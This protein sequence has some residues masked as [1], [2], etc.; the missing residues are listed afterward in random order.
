[1]PLLHCAY[2]TTAR[3]HA[4]YGGSYKWARVGSHCTGGGGSRPGGEGQG[5]WGGVCV[6]RGVP[7][8]FAF[9]RTP[10]GSGELFCERCAYLLLRCELHHT[11]FIAIA[12]RDMLDRSRMFVFIPILTP[13][14]PPA[15]CP[16]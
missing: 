9:F 10:G 4:P 11:L 14:P 5:T 12:H 7:Y 16:S 8:L 13:F 1:M 15:E 3:V 2:T 6:Y